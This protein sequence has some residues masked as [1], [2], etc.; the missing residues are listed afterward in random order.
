ML[1]MSRA[2]PTYVKTM[3]IFSKKLRQIIQ[4]RRQICLFF[5]IKI[6]NFDV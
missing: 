4:N 2:Y 3:S 1:Q 6:A 5:L